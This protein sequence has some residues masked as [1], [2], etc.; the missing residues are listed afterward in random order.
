MIIKPVLTEKSMLAAQ[1]GK[2]TFWVGL[3][4]TKTHIKSEVKKLFDVDAV[5]VKTIKVKGENKKSLRGIKTKTTDRKKA[6]IEVKKGQKIELFE[7]KTEK[8]TK[9]GKK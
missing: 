5:S 7:D 2:Y 6:I 1:S 9:K 3:T 4:T 8:K